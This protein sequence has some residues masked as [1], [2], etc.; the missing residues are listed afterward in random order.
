[1]SAM[2]DASVL[3][4]VCEVIAALRDGLGVEDLAARGVCSAAFARDVLYMLRGLG[5]H[6]MPQRVAARMSNVLPE[7]WDEADDAVLRETRG[8]YDR[9]AALSIRMDVAETVLLGRYLRIRGWG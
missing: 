9:I 2:A 4:K 6:D 1:M 5:A 8:Y 7:D 3:D